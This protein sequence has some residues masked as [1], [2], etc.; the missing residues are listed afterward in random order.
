M[1]KSTIHVSPAFGLG[2]PIVYGADE[3]IIPT[4]IS[5]DSIYTFNI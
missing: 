2:E 3:V 5:T 4:D 1:T